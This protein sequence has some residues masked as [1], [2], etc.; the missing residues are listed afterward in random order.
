MS[1][2]SGERRRSSGRAAA[3]VSVMAFVGYYAISRVVVNLFPFSS[4]AMFASAAAAH[5]DQ[6]RACHLLAVGPDGRALDVKA[7]RAWDCPSWQEAAQRSISELGCGPHFNVE[8]HIRSYLEEER[9]EDPSA[10]PVRLVRR[11]WAFR[12]GESVTT[13]DLPVASCKALPR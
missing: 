6:V 5:D 12:R 10:Q 13:R 2:G 11:M 9:G 4:F 7:F 1:A 3:V 8:E